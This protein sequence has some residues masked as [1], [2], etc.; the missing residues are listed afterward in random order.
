MRALLTVWLA[1]LS[2]MAGTNLAAPLYH[3]YAAEFGFSALVI[4]LIFTTYAAVL[5]PTLIVF[6]RLS[7]RVG[8]RPVLLAGI[9]S[10]AIG[11]VV[12]AVADSTVWLFVA[13]VFQGLA[14]GMISGPA[15]AALVELDPKRLEQRPALL[16]GIAQVGGSMLGPLVGGAL[17]EWAPAPLRLSYWVW[18]AVTAVVAAGTFTLPEPARRASE[19]WRVQWPRV[20]AEIGSDFARVSLTAGLSWGS[21]AL[22]LSIVPSYVEALLHTG[23]LALLG[24]VSAVALAASCVAQV[25]SQRRRV[26]VRRGQGVGLILLATG[27]V[28]LAVAAPTHSLALLMV[29]AL[30]GGAGHGAGVIGA[31]DELNTIAPPLRRGEVTSAFVCCVY[32]GVAVAGVGV[33][34]LS[35]GLGLT[36]AV[37]VVVAVL[38]VC[39]VATAGWQA[40]VATR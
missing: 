32:A 35:L 10:A 22:Y 37:T 13:R 20:P 40:R 12:F 16:A 28:L 21:V 17:A 34:L 29:A 6:G 5:I 27:L 23:N 11:L 4:T 9:A 38:A 18:L 25:I 19:R 8:R 3:V 2:V 15:T 1:W 24:A 31:Q 26:E 7:D 30:A 14:V 33:G 36:T 39:A